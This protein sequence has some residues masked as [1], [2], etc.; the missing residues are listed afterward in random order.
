[1]KFQRQARILDLIEKQEIE[2]QEEL[3]EQLRT[4]G[5]TTTQA[6]VSRDIKELRLIKILS[7]ETGKYKYA[8]A[9]TEVENSFSTRLRNIFRECVT[10]IDAAQNMV[11]IKTLPGLG[12]AAAMAID[13]MRDRR[14]VG[15]LGGDDT[16][17]VVMRDNDGAQDFCTHARKLLQ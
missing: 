3:S 16:V 10:D 11:V 7:A 12:Q 13:A 15:T 17:F 9:S 8:A 5:Y 4:L 6:T 14:V 2:T 1:M